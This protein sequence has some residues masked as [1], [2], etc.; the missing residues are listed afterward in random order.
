MKAPSGPSSRTSG[1]TPDSTLWQLIQVAQA[2]V[3]EGARQFKSCAS[4]CASVRLPTPAGPA[5]IMACGRRL[6]SIA[7]TS[8]S[9]ALGFPRKE[10]K[11]VGRCIGSFLV[12]KSTHRK[13]SYADADFFT[14]Q[15]HHG[16]TE[17]TEVHGAT[18][19]PQPTKN[20][21]FKKSSYG[22]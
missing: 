9:T 7:R 4:R 22:T 3:S 21:F 8:V 16:D 6:R 14:A 15:F 2:S 5:K 12:K 13:R 19:R 11:L 10:R 17:K 1:W 18:L 20:V